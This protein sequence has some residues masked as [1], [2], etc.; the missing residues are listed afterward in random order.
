M[1]GLI[2]PQNT[3]EIE[4]AVDLYGRPMHDFGFPFDDKFSSSSGQ[5]IDLSQYID[6]EV[7]LEG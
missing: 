4:S 5:T 2:I 3:K 6:D 1:S 7:I